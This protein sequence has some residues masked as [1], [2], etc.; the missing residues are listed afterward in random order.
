MS[1]TLA[2]FEIRKD[3]RIVRNIAIQSAMIPIKA[4][5]GDFKPKNRID[6]SMFRPNWTINQ[7]MAVLTPG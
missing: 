5:N 1:N 2:N 4:K 6:Q 3:F 7:S